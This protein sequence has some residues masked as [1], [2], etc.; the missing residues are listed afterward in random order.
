[1]GALSLQLAAQKVSGSDSATILDVRC[2][3]LSCR[4]VTQ[5]L[6]GSHAPGAAR[7]D[8][9][10]MCDARRLWNL[11]RSCRQG[12]SAFLL[13]ESSMIS[14]FFFFLKVALCIPHR[15]SRALVPT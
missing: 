7:E 10:T 4:T 5:R 14:Y 9:H 6:F 8:G 13:F 12:K 3:L 11:P 2:A 1:M 15:G